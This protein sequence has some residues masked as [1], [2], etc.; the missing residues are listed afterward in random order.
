M[1]AS[2]M[3]KFL[4]LQLNIGR[5]ADRQAL[6]YENCLR[7][8]LT[9]WVLNLNYTLKPMQ[10]GSD[11]NTSNFQLMNNAKITT[12]ITDKWKWNILN[13]PF[14]PFRSDNETELRKLSAKLDLIDAMKNRW[15]IAS[16]NWMKINKKEINCSKKI[17]KASFKIHGF[18]E[19]IFDSILFSTLIQAFYQSCNV[20]VQP[21]AMR[22]QMRQC[23]SDYY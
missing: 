17:D 14:K 2:Q 5:Q 4:M 15:I 13:L 21:N 12:T 20:P 22:L 3:M 1:N 7:C 19:C 10:S 16:T 23:K 8:R 6:E 11:H 18:P 9:L